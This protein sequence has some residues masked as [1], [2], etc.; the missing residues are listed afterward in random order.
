M[1]RDPV[2]SPLLI[3]FVLMYNSI[4]EDGISFLDG[5]MGLFLATFVRFQAG[6]LRLSVSGRMSLISQRQH[7]HT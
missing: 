1:G 6:E 5:P 4:H 3:D 7:S 2:R